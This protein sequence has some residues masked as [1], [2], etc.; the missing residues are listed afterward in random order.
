MDSTTFARSTAED[1]LEHKRWVMRES[2]RRYRMRRRLRE[3]EK[4]SRRWQVDLA[5]PSDSL[6]GPQRY[7]EILRKCRHMVEDLVNENN[8]IRSR[9]E[10]FGLVCTVGRRADPQSHSNSIN[11][12]EK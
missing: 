2:T 4:G 1:I 12:N 8:E 6:A 10:S 3:I 9:V 5:L 11:N 7:R